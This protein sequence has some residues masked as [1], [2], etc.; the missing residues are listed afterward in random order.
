MEQNLVLTQ[1]NNFDLKF[2]FPYSIEGKTI[3]VTAK[4]LHDKS[5]N[6]DKAII[7]KEYPNLV[8]VDAQ[9][10]I[11]IF[12]LSPEDTGWDSTLQKEKMPVGTYKFQ[13]ELWDRGNRLAIQLKNLSVIENNNKI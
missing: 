3:Y 1:R 8:G 7:N 11:F 5:N 12:S 13:I 4:T 2:K 9:E 10:G 6:N